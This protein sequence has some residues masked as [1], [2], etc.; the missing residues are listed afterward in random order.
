MT[1]LMR[2]QDFAGVDRGDA[3]FKAAT[4]KRRGLVPRPSG[5]PR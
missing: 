2:S 4:A 5:A 3:A 1:R